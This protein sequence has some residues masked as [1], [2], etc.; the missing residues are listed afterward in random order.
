MMLD[1]EAIEMM[2]RSIEEI[3]SLRRQ[4]DRLSPAAEAY[5][6]IRNIV[7]L[8]PKRSQGMSEDLV[9]RL[10]KRIKELESTPSEQI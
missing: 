10:E 4:V 3:K 9:W 5:D 2:R 6:V 8:L 1:K 7:D